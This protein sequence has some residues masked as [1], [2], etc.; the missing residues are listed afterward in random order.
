MPN[1]KAR[2]MLHSRF[3]MLL[4]AA[5]I[6][7]QPGLSQTPALRLKGVIAVPGVKGEF[8]HFAIDLVGQ[9]L[10]L[11]AEDQK[12]VEVLDVSSSKH[13]GSIGLF[14]RPHGLVFV[15]E[16]SRL[17]VSDGGDGS[18]KFVDVDGP[19]ISAAVKTALRADSVVY[20]RQ[21]QII[22][23]ANGGLVAKMDYSLV[24]AIS[25]QQERSVG[26]LRI[27]SMILEAMA[28]EQSGAR[29]FVNLMDRNAVAVIDRA[30]RELITTWPLS[31]AGEPS[32]MALD[33]SQHRLFVGCRKP[34]TLAVLDTDSGKT[35]ASLPSIGHADDVYYDPAHKRIYV[36]GGE[37]AVSV[38]QQISPND[39]QRLPDVPTGAGGKTSLFVPE[40][41]E[42]FVAIPAGSDSSAKVM[43][44][45]TEH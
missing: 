34:G 45:N 27:D 3:E 32:A 16:S 36:S 38:Y 35:V 28:V 19:K 43:I 24:T 1:R 39:Y 12:T 44:F 2:I 30:K 26:E 6:W 42:L 7:I 25:P 15:P 17:M 14:E 9:R 21:A 23:V 22:F 20:D 4:A 40:L 33:E 29:L 5:C 10:Y 8:D 37:G 41:H 11:A 18:G 31:A 13:I